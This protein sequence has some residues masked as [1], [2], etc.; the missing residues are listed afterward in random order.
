MLMVLILVVVEVK[1]WFI[2]D[3]NFGLCNFKG[4]VVGC[5]VLFL[6]FVNSFDVCVS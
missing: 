2:V 1:F 6:L 3:V 5:N 4:K